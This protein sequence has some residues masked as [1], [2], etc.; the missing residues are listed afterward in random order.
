MKTIQINL[1]EI[2]ELSEAAKNKA[3]ENIRN[4]E[5]FGID[6]GS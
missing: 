4:S 5:Y 1:Y 6:F 2:N 3:I